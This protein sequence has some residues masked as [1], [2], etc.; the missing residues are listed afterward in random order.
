MNR[1]LLYGPPLAGKTT[2]VEGVARASGTNVE[3]FHVAASHDPHH[4]CRGTRAALDSEWEVRTLTGPAQTD[5]M[6][7]ELLCDAAA[8]VL[9]LDGQRERSDAN[10]F[11]LERLA[12]AAPSRGCVVITKQDLCDAISLAATA[13]LLDDT[14]FA[15]WPVSFDGQRAVLALR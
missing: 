14:H 3:S 13:R 9:V 6:W 5:E 7:T 15:R 1:I 11:W 10:R 8:V 2:I 4:R 12:G